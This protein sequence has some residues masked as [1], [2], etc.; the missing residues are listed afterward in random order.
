M[1]GNK[2]RKVC[3]IFLFVL[4]PSKSLVLVDKQ[5]FVPAE[6]GNSRDFFKLFH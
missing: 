5:K 4:P 2:V 3:T 1:K 6:L